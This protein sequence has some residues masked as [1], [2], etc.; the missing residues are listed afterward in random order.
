[1]YNYL[2]IVGLALDVRNICH[3]LNP[4]GNEDPYS[5]LLRHP[6]LMEWGGE[7]NIKPKEMQVLQLLTTC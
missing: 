6:I 3:S 7:S 4:A 2:N 1:M 5:C